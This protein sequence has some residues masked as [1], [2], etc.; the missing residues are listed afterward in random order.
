MICVNYEE[1]YGLPGETPGDL[2]RWEFGCTYLNRGYSDG[3]FKYR[4]IN[5]VIKPTDKVEILQQQYLD[6]KFATGRYV[7]IYR[8]ELLAKIEQGKLKEIA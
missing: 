2:S 5:E 3:K 6:K 4:V 8:S 7:H 1:Y